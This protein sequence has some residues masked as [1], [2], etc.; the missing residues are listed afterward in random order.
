[1][2]S[3]ILKKNFKYIRYFCNN[4]LHLIYYII[5]HNA[6]INFVYFI[7]HFG[8]LFFQIL[9]TMDCNKF[10]FDIFNYFSVFFLQLFRSHNNPLLNQKYHNCNQDWRI[11]HQ[12]IFHY[13]SPLVF[14]ELSA[15]KSQPDMRQHLSDG[16]EI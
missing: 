5:C 12:Y 1:M 3:A 9:K 4:C 16:I 13:L 8:K 11:V 2:L 15:S 6:V 7:F 14:K 10:F